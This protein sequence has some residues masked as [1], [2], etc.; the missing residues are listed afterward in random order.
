MS[1]AVVYVS[2]GEELYENHQ[3]QPLVHIGIEGRMSTM[4][5]WV[6][7]VWVVPVG[8]TAWDLVLCVRPVEGRSMQPVLNPET[9]AGAVPSR[10]WVAIN[11]MVVGLHRG[12]VVTLIHPEAPEKSIVKRIVALEGDVIK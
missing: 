4:R 10:N 12:D 1:G 3:R 6:R 8:I 2:R 5:Q 9:Q 11:R 7:R